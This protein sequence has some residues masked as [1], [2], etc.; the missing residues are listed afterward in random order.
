MRLQEREMCKMQTWQQRGENRKFALETRKFSGK[1]C[2]AAENLLQIHCL[3][4]SAA[5]AGAAGSL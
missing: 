3:W 1:Q 4:P 5:P 2:R